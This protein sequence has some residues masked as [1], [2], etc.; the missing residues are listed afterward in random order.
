MLMLDVVLILILMIDGESMEEM[1]GLTDA[2][3]DLDLNDD[4]ED[5]IIWMI[6]VMMWVGDSG[7]ILI[8]TIFNE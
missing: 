3:E 8:V 1:R 7:H 6:L 4:V 5:N 2:C